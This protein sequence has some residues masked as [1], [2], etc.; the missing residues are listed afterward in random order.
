MALLKLPERKLRTHLITI[1]VGDLV[2][3]FVQG[4]GSSRI[5]NVEMSPAVVNVVLGRKNV[6]MWKMGKKNM[7]HFASSNCN[8]LKSVKLHD[9]L[10]VV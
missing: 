3:T 10:L 1:S 6:S 7:V 5:I 9:L 8:N 2:S 4:I